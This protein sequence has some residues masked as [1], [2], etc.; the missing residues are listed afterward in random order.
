[1]RAR[2]AS[3]C[4][5]NQM[6]MALAQQSAGARGYDTVSSGRNSLGLCIR[7]QP[8]AHS[9]RTHPHAHVSSTEIHTHMHRVHIHCTRVHLQPLIDKGHPL[10]NL[11]GYLE[12]ECTQVNVLAYHPIK[13]THSHVICMYGLHTR[14]L[15]FNNEG[16]LVAAPVGWLAVH[17]HT[18][19]HIHTRTDMFA[20][21]HTRVTLCIHA[22]PLIF[23]DE[24]NLVATPE[25]RLAVLTQDDMLVTPPPERGAP[26]VLM[27]RL[28]ELA[29]EVGWELAGGWLVVSRRL[30]W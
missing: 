3:G 17:T 1:M 4:A 14:R 8:T 30:A 19:I 2:S 7:R 6:Y 21:F 9:A 10:S 18:H 29:P 13:P 25:G 11:E 20:Q 28:L 5:A 26:A 15:I 16:S 12:I 22:Q 27:E 24:G 23:D